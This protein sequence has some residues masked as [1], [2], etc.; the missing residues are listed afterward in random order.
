MR[1]RRVRRIGIAAAALALCL[2]LLALTAAHDRAPSM[3]DAQAAPRAVL[4]SPVSAVATQAT[5]LR[6]QAGMM[7]AG[8][9]LIG[10]AAAVRR[11]A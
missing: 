1:R 11:A 8:M 9:I 4:S 2:P 10:A 5:D 3:E 6:E 7:V